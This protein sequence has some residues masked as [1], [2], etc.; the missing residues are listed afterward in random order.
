MT[1]PQVKVIDQI[2]QERKNQDRQWGGP[3]HDNTH[4]KDDW[5]RFIHYQF[6]CADAR[7]SNLRS[8]LIKI[9]ALAVAAVES[10]DRK[11]NQNEA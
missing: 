5:L 3:E 10:I 2:I 8:R 4:D 1:D 11:E 7:D 6:I 9:A